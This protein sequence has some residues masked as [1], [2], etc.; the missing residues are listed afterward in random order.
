MDELKKYRDEID[1]IDK[2]ITELFEK[3]MDISK[4]IAKCKKEKNISYL[5]N[6]EYRFVLEGFFRNLMNLSKLIQNEENN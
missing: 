3:R 6:K 2:Q 5:K 4:E 1:N